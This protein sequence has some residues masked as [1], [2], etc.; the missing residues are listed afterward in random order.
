[1]LDRS[2]ANPLGSNP[3]V[4]REDLQLAAR[5]LVEPLLPFFSAGGVRVNLGSQGVLFGSESEELEGFARP[6]YAIVPLTLGGGQFEH[7]P[8]YQRGLALAEAPRHRPHSPA[9][10]QPDLATHR[11]SLPRRQRGPR[12]APVGLC[13]LRQ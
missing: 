3:L 11:V 8:L 2:L 10:H 7:W 4:G 6:L 5:Q 12:H 1:M 9:R 13:G